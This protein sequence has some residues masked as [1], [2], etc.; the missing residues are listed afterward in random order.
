MVFRCCLD[1]VRICHHTVRVCGIL[2]LFRKCDAFCAVALKLEA[3]IKSCLILGNLACDSLAFFFF[4]HVL[5]RK[6]EREIER[7]S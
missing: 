1:I 5:E 2:Q 4:P 6:G 7:L 3:E